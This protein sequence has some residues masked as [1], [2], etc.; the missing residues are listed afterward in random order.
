MT[1]Q[2]S[3]YF[4]IFSSPIM[5]R[6][7]IIIVFAL[8][9]NNMAITGINFNALNYKDFNYFLNIL[10]LGLIEIPGILLGLWAIETRFGRRW[11]NCLLMAT[12]GVSLCITIFIPKNVILITTLTLIGKLS[13]SAT[14]MIIYQQMAEIF[15]TNI[16]NQSISL[17]N[18][19]R[20]IFSIGVPYISSLGQNGLW[21]PLS[22]FGTFCLFVAVLQSFLP[23][24]MNEPLPQNIVEAEQLGSES[25]FFALSKSEFSDL[26]LNEVSKNDNKI[27]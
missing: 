17:A 16:R 2:K 22:I 3:G 4:V 18:S 23:E 15:P 9:A 13:I 26:S 19:V 6:R 12:C 24:T 20:K 7:W 14:F 10:L 25:K 21:I 27:L 1:D 5:L 11:S 8:I